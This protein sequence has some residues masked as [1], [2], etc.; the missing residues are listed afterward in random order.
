MPLKFFDDITFELFVLV[1]LEPLKSAEP[2]TNCGKISETL[3]I[4]DEEHC[5]VA[6][7]G[8]ES[9]YFSF[10]LS[11]RLSSSLNSDPLLNFSNSDIISLL[12]LLKD[13]FHIS[14]Y[15]VPFLPIFLHSFKT[16]LGIEKGLFSHFNFFLTR[17][18]SSSPRGDP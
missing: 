14:S 3:S 17:E 8:F 11:I 4:T 2:P 1:L 9:K 7:L 10:S 16:S 15:S 12:F 13:C 5:L 18:I 6:K